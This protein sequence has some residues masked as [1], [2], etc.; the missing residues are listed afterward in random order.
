MKTS[1]F[2]RTASL[3]LPLLLLACSPQTDPDPIA[4]GEADFSRYVAVG[5]SLT[6]GYMDGGLYRAGQ[7]ASYPNLLAQQFRLAGGGEFGQPLFSEAEENGSGYLQPKTLNPLQ[8][9][10]VTERL[11]LRSSSPT[12]YT[13]FS[14]ENQNF[15][16]P[17][18]GVTDVTTAGYGAAGSNP[19]FERLLPTGQ[20]QTTY[21]AYIGEAKPTFFTYWL[22]N[23]DLLRYV[24]SGGTRPLSTLADF[25][26]GTKQLFDALAAR[27][28]KGAVGNL[29]DPA[30]LPLVRSPAE[31]M[32]YRK[33][34]VGPY[35]IATG[36]GEVRVANETDRILATADSIGYL[37]AAG[38][39]KGFF[40]IYPLQNDEVLDADELLQLQKA[41]EGFNVVL[42]TEA[43]ARNWPLADLNVLFRKA[44][45][46]YLDYDGT[47]VESDLFQD[48]QLSANTIH[49][50]DGIS[51]NPRGQALVANEFIDAINRTYQSQLNRLFV[52]RY[53]ALRLGK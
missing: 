2:F 13:K 18:L 27:G 26:T 16:V 4:N 52:G 53:T 30:L 3:A 51:L 47:R 7:L 9:V 11:A 1:V 37:S 22:G 32:A 45:Q 46:G 50:F 31:L 48:G 25:T 41:L 40:K 29:P 42:R 34:R 8:L 24:A 10:P 43:S 6:A 21:L 35:W 20:E 44:K 28:A 5:G 33:D 36:T 15:G 38:F 19:F 39:P 17:G 49:S 12:L 14:G 23:D